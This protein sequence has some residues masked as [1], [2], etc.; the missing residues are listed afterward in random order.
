[1]ITAHIKTRLKVITGHASDLS[2]EAAT[3][4]G[5]SDCAGNSGANRRSCKCTALNPFAEDWLT[6]GTT[7]FTQSFDSLPSPLTH[8]A[9][10]MQGTHGHTLSMEPVPLSCSITVKSGY[11]LTYNYKQKIARIALSYVCC[12]NSKCSTIGCRTYR[13]DEYR[14]S[15]YQYFLYH[16]K[17]PTNVMHS[18]ETAV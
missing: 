7:T 5:S 9:E 4:T 14:Y 8:G 3:Q 16:C 6:I 11:K 17:R 18:C 13:G 2:T 10:L 15:W 12:T 1:M